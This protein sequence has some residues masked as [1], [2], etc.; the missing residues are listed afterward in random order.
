M[1]LFDFMRPATKDVNPNVS[2]NTDE[3]LRMDSISHPWLS[4]NNEKDKLA[5]MT[6]SDVSDIL[7]ETARKWMKTMG[8]LGKVI[9]APAEDATKNGFEVKTGKPDI[10]RKIQNRMYELDLQTKLNECLRYMRLHSQGSV[11]YY[12][13][14]SDIPQDS[15]AL[16][17]PIPSKINQIAS[18]NVIEPDFFQPFFLNVNPLSSL[19][20][21]PE[22]RIYGQVI[23]PSRFRWFIKDFNRTMKTGKSVLEDC[24][25]A[26][27][28]NEIGLWSV[29]H[30]LLELS[31]KIF[32]S[33]DIKKGNREQTAKFA[34]RMRDVLS[35]NSVIAIDSTEDFD[36][37]TANLGGLKDI[38]DWILD[39]I[40]M[41]SEIPQSRL[42]GAAHGTLSSGDYDTIA[43]YEKIERLQKNVLYK[44]INDVVHLI[45]L[46]QN[47][48][49]QDWEICFHP[50][51]KLSSLDEAELELK[52][53]NRDK[54][55]IESGKIS[56]QE[57]RLLDP[58]L[59]MLE[60]LSTGE[61]TTNE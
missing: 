8:V 7:P 55:D 56:P 36:K 46:E 25:D 57:A 10:D 27:K 15:N 60:P 51:W 29:S 23:D 42:K 11:L 13:L 33:P 6:P 47:L 43:Y 28:A 20:N 38:F 41:L 21:I 12:V 26:V 45:N 1:A 50:L 58:R 37:K 22:M 30:I 4:I 24:F 5:N 59:A 9:N 3:S 52:R 34:A 35:T 16:S 48:N 53:A 2:T 17:Q 49:L 40:A 54:I 31:L 14:E 44:P 39:N 19:Y 18:L 61:G 32:K